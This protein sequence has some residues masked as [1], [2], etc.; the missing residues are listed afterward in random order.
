PTS[1][2]SMPMKSAAMPT[3]PR[4]DELSYEN[5]V[6]PPRQ[7]AKANANPPTTTSNP[8]RNV[9]RRK[10]IMC[11]SSDTGNRNRLE[12]ALN[13]GSLLGFGRQCCRDGSSPDR[14]DSKR[15]RKSQE[16]GHL[17]SRESRDQRH[18]GLPEIHDGTKG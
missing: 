7:P 2:T 3:N 13:P 5:A 6:M 9:G 10:R 16:R 1:I 11:A 18:T 4:Y 14:P 8:W 15:H 17:N 12:G